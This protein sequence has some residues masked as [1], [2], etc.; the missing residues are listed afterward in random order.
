MLVLDV[1]SAE[2]CVVVC[3]LCVICEVGVSVAAVSTVVAPKCASTD[4]PVR[5]PTSVE[6]AIQTFNP[7]VNR[8]MIHI[9]SSFSVIRLAMLMK[10]G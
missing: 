3:V 9:P 1:S 4:Q 2:T 6:P 7:F 8:F 5:N 10:A